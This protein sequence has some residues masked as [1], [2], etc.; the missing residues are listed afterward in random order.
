MVWFAIEQSTSL[1]ADEAELAALADPSLSCSLEHIKSA[2]NQASVVEDGVE[3]SQFAADEAID[4]QAAG[5]AEEF[6]RRSTAIG[7]GYPFT[8]D[9]TVLTASRA[10]AEEAVAYV[11][12]LLMSADGLPGR[13][14][15]PRFFEELVTAA[16]GRYLVG[17]S[18]RFGFPHREPVP[19]HPDK[20]VNYLA[21]QINQPRIH[22]RKI[23]WRE[24]DMGVDAVAWKLFSDRK[25]SKIVLLANCS[26]GANW[27]SKL[28][29]L[30]IDKWRRMIDFGSD[31]VRVFAVPW[32][33]DPEDWAEITDY[34]HIVLD[35]TRAASLL[36]GWDA[37]TEIRGWC[38]RRLKDAALA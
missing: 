29:E 35:R 5:A 19:S 28:G 38:N 25:R 22:T 13:R 37:G 20:A 1:L 12:L 18:L 4:I 27:K 17:E 10:W 7:D 23:R 16:L 32:T 21:H 8:F 15:G 3:G 31:P 26:T 9:G 33:P 34:G 24:K 11:F 6:E 30:S 2:L 14:H 36:P